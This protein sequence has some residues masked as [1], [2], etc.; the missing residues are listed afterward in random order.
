MDLWYL[1][2]IALTGLA[3]FLIGRFCPTNS[4][5]NR[6]RKAAE[7]DLAEPY[8]KRVWYCIDRHV[9]PYGPFGSDATMIILENEDLDSAR[10]EFLY[11]RED[12][13]VNDRVRLRFR[14]DNE[15]IGAYTMPFGDILVPFPA[16]AQPASV[17]TAA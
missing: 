10:L 2:V 13:Q 16:K 15:P 9:G 17:R 4:V 8:T 1:G 12:I 14:T 11:S 3:S 5:R 6:L 7:R